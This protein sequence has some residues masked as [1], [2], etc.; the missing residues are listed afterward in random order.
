MNYKHLFAILTAVLFTVACGNTEKITGQDS[1]GLKIE[2]F[3][4]KKTGGKEGKFIKYYLTGVVNEESTYRDNVLDGVRT[5]YD[6]NG[7]KDVTETYKSGI[8]QGEFHAFYPS[9]ALK[10]KGMYDKNAM[11]GV[12]ISYYENGTLKEEVTIANNEENGP[13]KEYAPNG[14][15]AAEGSYLNGKEHGELKEYNE[16]GELM[17]IANCDNGACITSWRADHIIAK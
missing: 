2:Y 3:R 8:Y 4:N 17:R 13:F 1:D 15:I 16:Q 12:W 5:M 10:Q 7:K 11:V 9:G 6:F 14:K